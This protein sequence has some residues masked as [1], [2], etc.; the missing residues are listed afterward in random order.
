M[1]VHFPPE[2]EGKLNQIAAEQGK[3]SESLVRE[4]VERLIG[5]DDWFVSE[6]EKGLAAADRGD[7]IEH[8]DVRALIDSRYP[9]N[10]SQH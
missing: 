1:L 2:L 10:E 9:S 7:L 5:Y 8:S 4:A 3:N 6:V